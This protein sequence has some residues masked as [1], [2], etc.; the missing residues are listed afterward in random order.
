[1]CVDYSKESI[2]HSARSSGKKKKM[3]INSNY[4]QEEEIWKH[5]KPLIIIN[6][7][8][9][10]IPLMHTLIIGKS[11]REKL[12]KFFEIMEMENAN[13]NSVYMKV[14]KL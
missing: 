8:Q 9:L 5:G 13:S 3:E 7:M 4:F 11:K 2:I 10:N 1:M 14:F 6:K 12:L